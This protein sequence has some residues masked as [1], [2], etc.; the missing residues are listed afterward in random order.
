MDL[1]LRHGSMRDSTWNDQKLALRESDLPVREIHGES[2]LD[3]QEQLFLVLTM[4]TD[5]LA[6]K[7]DQL[8]LLAVQLADDLGTPVILESRKRL[9]NVHFVR[10]AHVRLSIFGD[11]SIQRFATPLL[12]EFACPLLLVLRARS[13]YPTSGSVI[14]VQ[15]PG[16]GHSAL[17]A[18]VSA[19]RRRP[20]TDRP[21]PTSLDSFA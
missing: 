11:G 16:S 3:D 12:L 17:L 19:A 1:F 7:L 13:C 15:E 2:S 21:T 9:L 5:E 6:V 4:M 14:M 10:H 18:M 20:A 8:D